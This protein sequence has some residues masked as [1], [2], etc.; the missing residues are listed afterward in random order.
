MSKIRK[1]EPID[2]AD[3]S[4]LPVK[5]SDSAAN[6]TTLFVKTSL[7]YKLAEA[8]MLLVLTVERAL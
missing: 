1:S 5:G 6:R 8:S 4:R 3:I 2:L 7:Y